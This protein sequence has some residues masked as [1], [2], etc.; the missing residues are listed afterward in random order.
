MLRRSVSYGGERVMP[1]KCL[2][3]ALFVLVL[4]PS[5]AAGTVQLMP[6]VTYQRKLEWTAAGPVVTYVIKAPKPGGL[7]S[8]TPLLSNNA[9]TGRET[10]S[11]MERRVSGQ[12]TT[13]GVNGDFFNWNGGWPSG[14]LMQGGVLEHHP[15]QN[16]SAVGIDSGGTLHVDREPF[17]ASWRDAASL[18]HPIAAVNEPPRANATALFTPVWGDS[19]PALKGTQVTLEPFPAARPFADLAG[20]VTRIVTDS[21]VPIPRDGAVLVGR[22]TAAQD[23]LNSTTVGGPLG[24]H[25]ALSRDWSS[26]TDA[27]GGGPALVRDGKPIARSGESLTAVQLYGRD[28]RTSIGQRPDGSL[29]IVAADGRRRGWSVGISNWDLALALV[30]YGCVSGFALDS[31]GSTTVAFD[32]HVLNRPSDPTG[33]RPVGE[34]LVVGYTGVYAAPT[35]TLSPNGDGAGDR[36]TFSYKVVRPATV[37]A[38]IVAA[39]GTSRELD[40]G[41]KAPGTYRVSWD[42]KDPTGAAAAEGRYRWSVTA[43]DDL[44]RTSTATRAFTI[45]DTLGFVRVGRNARTIG[46]TLARD[47]AIR[48][49]VEDRYGEILRTVA[50]GHRAA[51]HVTVHWNGRDGR[52]KRVPAGAYVVHVAASSQIG[53]SEL[54]VPVRIRR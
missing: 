35:T 9:I 8:L 33:E 44:A 48:V 34:A 18:D 11:S 23:L 49:T 54:R 1:R 3:C 13:I 5:A 28:P 17:S 46:F 24:V 39:D 30:R 19:T 50:A 42:G 29:V 53:L 36:E 22:G 51:G 7:Y 21:P 14:L 26:V 31:G 43:T 37:S 38:K 15:A 2:L 10:V 4:A 12:M 20:T 16:R 52:R 41:Q 27:V 47:A 45:D 6:G 25:L 32:G 40:A